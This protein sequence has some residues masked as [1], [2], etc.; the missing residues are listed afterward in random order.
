[1]LW[2]LYYGTPL[3]INIEEWVE[4]GVARKCKLSWDDYRRLKAV[5]PDL[6]Q[7]WAEKR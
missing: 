1:M 2:K 3:N 4:R 6:W 7:R 5:H